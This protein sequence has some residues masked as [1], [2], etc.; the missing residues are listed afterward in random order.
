MVDQASSPTVCL[1]GPAPFG[2]TGHRPSCETN[3]GRWPVLLHRRL[4]RR[5]LEFPRQGCPAG[6]ARQVCLMAPGRGRATA[7]GRIPFRRVFVLP[8]RSSGRY[9]G[10]PLGRR[11]GQCFRPAR[12]PTVD[13]YIRCLRAFSTSRFLG[14]VRRFPIV[15]A[16]VPPSRPENLAWG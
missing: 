2:G 5:R 9:P 10:R 15:D 4:A 8:R 1:I 12:L 3:E 14:V 16:R 13:T 11:S 6:H 7:V